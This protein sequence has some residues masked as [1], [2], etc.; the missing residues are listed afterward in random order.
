M[1][2][3]VV[4]LLSLSMAGWG[5]TLARSM[6]RASDAYGKGVEAGYNHLLKSHIKKFKAPKRKEKR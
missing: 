1:F 4:I 5:W 6:K 2:Y 3:G